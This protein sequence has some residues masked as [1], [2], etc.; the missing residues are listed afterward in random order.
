MMQLLIILAALGFWVVIFTTLAKLLRTQPS[1]ISP[2]AIL[3]VVTA[4]IPLMLQL[5]EAGE[6]GISDSLQYGWGARR[7]MEQG[8]FTIPLNGNAYPPRFA[9][10]FS[11]LIVAPTYLFADRLWLGAI[12]VL[13]CGGVTLITASYLGQL[14][15]GISGSVI[16]I[17]ALTSFSSFRFFATNIMTEVPATML[18]LLLIAIW[19]RTKCGRDWAPLEGLLVAFAG[20]FRPT[21][22]STLLWTAWRYRKSLP[23]LSLALSPTLLAIAFSWVYQLITFEDVFRTGYHYWVSVPYDYLELTFSQNY[24]SVNLNSLGWLLQFFFVAGLVFVVKLLHQRAQ[25]TNSNDFDL[26][27]FRRGLGYA[28]LVAVPQLLFYAFYFY[29]SKR[30]YLPLFLTLIALT[31]PA[32]ATL[33]DKL[34]KIL[35]PLLVTIWIIG[36]SLFQGIPQRSLQTKL[37]HLNNEIPNNAIIVSDLDPLLAEEYLVRNSDR[38]Y[39]PASRNVE[40]ASKLITPRRL[41]HL[42]PPPSSPY[43]HRAE[44][45]LRSNE[46]LDVFPWVAD[47]SPEK[48]NEL[49]FHTNRPVFFAQGLNAKE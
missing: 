46:V 14:L 16:A 24:L 45:L 34:P 13:L 18:L 19:L 1:G 38:L 43:D 36:I 23:Q 33:V 29:P 28:A 48:L 25:R 31:A 11:A 35:K 21:M 40:F 32:L 3:T 44:A 26:N 9:P 10:W 7:L 42:L 27:I 6:F 5:P 30:F 2:S 41:E 17:L 15:S 47:T 12:P 8:S 20:S 22:Y 37:A 4:I 39:V 49:S